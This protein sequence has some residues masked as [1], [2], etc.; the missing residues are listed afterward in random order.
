MRTVF[1]VL[2]YDFK[3]KRTHLVRKKNTIERDNFRRFKNQ[4]RYRTRRFHSP[5]TI[6]VF[7]SIVPPELCDCA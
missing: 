6:G 5:A 1:A 3:N 4:N 2:K 7:P